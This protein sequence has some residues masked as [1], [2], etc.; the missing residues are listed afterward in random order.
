MNVIRGKAIFFRIWATTV[1]LLYKLISYYVRTA[2]DSPTKYKRSFGSP[3]WLDSGD[4]AL[5]N[6][7]ITLLNELAAVEGGA[8]AAHDTELCLSHPVDL[9]LCNELMKKWKVELCLLA[10]IT[11]LW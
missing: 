1:L 6:N 7:P 11:I 9:W 3:T 8:P 4:D 10:A 2:P 5:K